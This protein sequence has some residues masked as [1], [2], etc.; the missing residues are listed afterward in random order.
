MEKDTEKIVE[1][2]QRCRRAMY[3]CHGVLLLLV[4][5]VLVEVRMADF[6]VVS[7]FVAGFGFVGAA[8][9]SKALIGRVRGISAEVVEECQKQS[10]GQDRAMPDAED[11]GD[12]TPAAVD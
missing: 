10:R 8:F 5:L 11:A 3:F 1:E 4:G 6:V 7:V 9:V 12:Q 2:I